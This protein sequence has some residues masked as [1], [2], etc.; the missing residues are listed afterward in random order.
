MSRKTVI[1]LALVLVPVALMVAG[2]TL[3]IGGNVFSN[4]HFV[5]AFAIGAT[6]LVLLSVGFFALSFHSA[7]SGHDDQVRDERGWQETDSD[8]A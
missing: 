1:I 6:G 3:G 4:A 8:G 5:A 2:A 7:R